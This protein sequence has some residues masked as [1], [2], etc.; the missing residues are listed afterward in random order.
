MGI[1][2]KDIE[3][4][5]TLLQALSS[6]ETDLPAMARSILAIEEVKQKTGLSLGELEVKVVS[7]REEAEKLAPDGK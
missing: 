3:K 1:E 6:S 2:P 5:H 4:C 7:L